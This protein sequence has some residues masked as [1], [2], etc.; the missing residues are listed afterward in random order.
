MIPR[1]GHAPYLEAAEEFVAHVHAFI[2]DHAA[3]RPTPTTQGDPT[4]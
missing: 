2:D 4:V 1:T 3:T